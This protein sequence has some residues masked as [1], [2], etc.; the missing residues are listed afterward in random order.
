M[1]NSSCVYYSPSIVH[2]TG[3]IKQNMIGGNDM[4]CFLKLGQKI[5]F[6]ALSVAMLL[7]AFMVFMGGWACAEEKTVAEQ[8]LD[9]MLENHEISQEQYD[10]LLKQ[11][12]AEKMAAA[13]KIAEAQKAAMAKK[14]AALMEEKTTDLMP[15]AKRPKALRRTITILTYISEAGPRSILQMPN[16]IAV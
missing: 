7:G 2:R 9:I 10:A 12:E 15:L 3:G 14:A 6:K 11:A 16:R 13:R 5:I 4:K 8:I 1:V